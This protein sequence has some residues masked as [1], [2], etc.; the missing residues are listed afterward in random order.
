M[1][2]CGIV[3]LSIKNGG[4]FHS[5]IHVYQ[6]IMIMM[7]YLFE[8]VI[9]LGYVKLPESITLTSDDLGKIVEYNWDID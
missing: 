1:A 5:Y 7:F 8:M 2:I 9:I 4:S 3:D 6:R